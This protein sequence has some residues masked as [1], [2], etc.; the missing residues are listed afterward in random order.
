MPVIVN[1]S[2]LPTLSTLRDLLDIVSTL[3]DAANPFSSL[4]TLRSA[5]ALLIRVGTTLELNPTW[6]AW[7]QS[8]SDDESLLDVLL[9]VGQYVEHLVEASPG[10]LPPSPQTGP[11][12][13]IQAIDL[14]NWLAII[15]EIVQLLG[16]LRG[17]AA[18]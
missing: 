3:R 18:A 5:I 8:I 16:K 14:G 10:N 9:A 15:A 13:T 12:T 1:R 2:L 17:Q 7:L 6:L 11:E 4:D